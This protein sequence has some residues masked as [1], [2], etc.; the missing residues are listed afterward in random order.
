MPIS[1]VAAFPTIPAVRSRTVPFLVICLALAGC[2]SGPAP[3]KTARLPMLILQQ[4]D[5]P[6]G[7]AEFAHGPQVRS[8]LH[9]GPREDPERF[10][11]LGGW[12][13]RFRRAAVVT[14][15]VGGPLVIESRADVF[16]ST[17]AAK[18]D[19]NAYQAE[20]EAQPAELRTEPLAPPPV[21]DD[22]RAFRFG[23]G[24][25]RFVLVAWRKANA[26]A[27]ILVEGSSITPADAA[28]L[29]RRQ[30]AHLQAAAS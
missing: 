17:G 11:R 28:R 5:V 12:I 20:Y 9:P 3:I 26:T 1:L 4:G 29:A 19:L 8:D 22:A 15:H 2:G 27:S 23:S 7:F 25:D 14:V 24:L 6:H 21:G 10:G 16:P 13:S 18:K 30:E